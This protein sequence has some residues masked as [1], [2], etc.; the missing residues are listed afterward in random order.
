MQIAA[1][2]SSRNRTK[3]I[4]QRFP[5][6]AIGIVEEDIFGPTFS[7]DIEAEKFRKYLK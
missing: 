2:T 1:N 5:T 4:I 7:I 3:A 6:S